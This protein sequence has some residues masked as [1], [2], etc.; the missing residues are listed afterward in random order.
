MGAR[1]E[2]SPGLTWVHESGP[3][4]SPPS[5]GR[6]PWKV[7]ARAG[8]AGG[9]WRTGKQGSGAL[10]CSLRVLPVPQQDL[11]RGGGGE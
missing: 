7:V 8:L 9:T 5:R 6:D 2:K 1:A 3:P 11:A 10:I 4:W